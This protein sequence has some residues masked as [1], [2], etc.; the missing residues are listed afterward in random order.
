MRRITSRPTG[1]TLI[2]LLVVIAII[3]VL[4]AI[5]FPVF[6]QAKAKA[7]Q[8]TCLSN[9]K[10]IGLAF[11]MYAADWDDLLPV[12]SGGPY[13]WTYGWNSL[14]AGDPMHAILKDY[15]AS[16]V[17][18]LEPQMKNSN[19]WFCAADVWKDARTVS[20]LDDAAAVGEVSYSVF[21]QWN[22]WL[23]SADYLDP[24][25]PAIT[26]L[27]DINGMLPTEQGL[28]IDNGL[29][30]DAHDPNAVYQFPHAEG[31]NVLF[32]DGHTKF[33]PA[34]K[35]TSVHPPLVPYDATP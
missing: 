32:L 31:Y 21:T 6:A 14:P 34:G 25:C 7:R 13:N 20:D 27:M 23:D 2:E 33:I 17:A 35:F 10:Q 22:T 15:M 16:I 1:F 26:V 8:T 11:S 19:I 5:L 3:A 28:M 4:A 9:L 18:A 30:P 12:T 29:P 24:V